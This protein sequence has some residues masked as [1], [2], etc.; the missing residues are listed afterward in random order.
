M[1][2]HHLFGEV[3]ISSACELNYILA[4]TD[5]KNRLNKMKK[6][7]VMLEGKCKTYFGRLTGVIRVR[8]KQISFSVWSV[9]EMHAIIRQHI[10]THSV[11]PHYL[12]QPKENLSSLMQSTLQPTLALRQTA[13]QT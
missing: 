4:P 3:E 2:G 6:V 7:D 12:I 9:M 1:L 13:V 8:K 10:R 11:C 5:S